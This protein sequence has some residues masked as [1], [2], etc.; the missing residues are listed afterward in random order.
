MGPP[1]DRMFLAWPSEP[2]SVAP[3]HLG[4]PGHPLSAAWPVCQCCS[5]SGFTAAASLLAELLIRKAQTPSRQRQ[6][7]LC[8]GWRDIVRLIPTLSSFAPTTPKTEIP[9]QLHSLCPTPLTFGYN[10]HQ[11]REEQ[12]LIYFKV[13]SWFVFK[14]H[15]L[16]FHHD[17][18]MKHSSWLLVCFVFF[19]RHKSDFKC[20]HSQE[21]EPSSC[22]CSH[23]YA[24]GRLA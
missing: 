23:T 1:N 10:R 5:Q 19:L 8:L 21:A 7:H 15:H 9:S 17:V 6:E 2:I 20:S 22:S 24:G 14:T 18:L 11:R 4:T 13:F 16:C 12:L 3:S